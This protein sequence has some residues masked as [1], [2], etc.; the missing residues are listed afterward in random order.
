MYLRPSLR[1]TRLRLTCW[2]GIGFWN[3]IE[4]VGWTLAASWGY[5]TSNACEYQ[6]ELTLI[7]ASAS[8]LVGSVLQ[9]YE[10]LEKYPVVTKS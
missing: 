10:A 2:D 6:S 1:D 9:W 5:C 3:M 4:S 8:F 7:W